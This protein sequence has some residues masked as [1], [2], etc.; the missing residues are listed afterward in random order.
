MEMTLQITCM[1]YLSILLIYQND[2]SE[3]RPRLAYW[4]MCGVFEAYM[5]AL[6]HVSEIR[7][8]TDWL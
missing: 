1:T 7:T 5:G 3:F 4:N 6:V 2:K 8:N